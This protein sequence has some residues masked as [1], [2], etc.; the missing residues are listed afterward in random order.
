MG[1]KGEQR[2]GKCVE[3]AGRRFGATWRALA[4]AY[5]AL[6]SLFDIYGILQEM[7]LL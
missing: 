2:S 3:A 5:I 6:L 7:S 4:L 1:E